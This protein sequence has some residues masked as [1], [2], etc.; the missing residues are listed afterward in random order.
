MSKSSR[1]I[2]D[3]SLV[4]VTM[5]SLSSHTDWGPSS[6]R[7]FNGGLVLYNYT[8]RKITNPVELVRVIQGKSTELQGI[9]PLVVSFSE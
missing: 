4:A 1:M 2:S 8:G 7:T 6:N 3:C 9:E 5:Q